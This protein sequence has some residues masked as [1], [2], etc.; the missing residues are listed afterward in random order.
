MKRVTKLFVLIFIFMWI[1]LPALRAAEVPL[2]Q[3]INQAQDKEGSVAES[4]PA[5]DA[6]IQHEPPEAKK[7]GKIEK[8]SEYDSKQA[9]FLTFILFIKNLK[10]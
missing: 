2:V 8:G 9:R 10:K 7:E 1:S 5:T 3:P 4:I 6:A